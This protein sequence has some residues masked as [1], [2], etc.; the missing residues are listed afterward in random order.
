MSKLICN[1]NKVIVGSGQSASSSIVRKQRLNDAY[2]P[3]DRFSPSK[4]IP[5]DL[6]PATREQGDL[7]VRTMLDQDQVEIYQNTT[8]CALGSELTHD[9][10][11]GVLRTNIATHHFTNFERLIY[12]VMDDDAATI[13][14]LA[15]PLEE[16]ACFEFED[17]A[18]ILN[19]AIEQER[20]NIVLHLAQLT[21]NKPDIR[22][23]LLQHKFRQDQIC[24]V[25]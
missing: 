5:T 15:I 16:L 19:F 7:V 21:S 23:K 14:R 8:M 12:A 24:A 3:P 6:Q 22:K 25:H 2:S 11:D 20:V 1:E 13:D 18:N 10:P 9:R 4:F 17:G